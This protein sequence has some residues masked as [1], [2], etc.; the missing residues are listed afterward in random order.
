MKKVS[1]ESAIGAEWGASSYLSDDVWMRVCMAS[2]KED[3]DS[4]REVG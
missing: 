1:R 4:G 2:R 3:E